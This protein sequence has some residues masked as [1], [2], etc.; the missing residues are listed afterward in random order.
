MLALLGMEAHEI[1]GEK[2]PKA[3]GAPRPREQS[4]S[5]RLLSIRRAAN[6]A[7]LNRLNSVE[8]TA[9]IVARIEEREAREA[10][11]PPREYSLLEW[12]PIEYV[13]FLRTNTCQHCGHSATTLDRTEVFL[14]MRR[15]KPDPANARLLMPVKFIAL[16][17]LPRRVES[18]PSSSLFCA[19]CAKD[20]SC[21]IPTPSDIQLLDQALI[22]S[23]PDSVQTQ[24]SA[25]LPISPLKSPDS[26]SPS[27]KPTESA[28]SPPSPPY[29][30]AAV[31]T[32]SPAGSGSTSDGSAIPVTAPDLSSLTEEQQT[33]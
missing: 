1:K 5:E 2:R 22:V 24:L 18:L 10:K 3:K 27:T 12:R 25:M 26:L 9:A 8:P 14:R 21:S 15:R 6:K 32:S 31:L 30:P 11:E 20:F 19:E 29:S 28:G 23:L 7:A 33:A 13:L 16:P 17:A 4:E